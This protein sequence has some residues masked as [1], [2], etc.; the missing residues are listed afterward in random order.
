ML[1]FRDHERDVR[2]KA[3]FKSRRERRDALKSAKKSETDGRTR[4]TD[5]ETELDWTGSSDEN[6]FSDEDLDRVV[7]DSRGGE[8]V[9]N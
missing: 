7:Y 5:S 1:T 3:K 6:N 2:R 8:S 9:S 4:S